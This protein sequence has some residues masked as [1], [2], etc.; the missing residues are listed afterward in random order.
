MKALG[1]ALEVVATDGDLLKIDL[2]D[3]LN[4]PVLVNSAEVARD[5]KTRYSVPDP[6]SE[7]ERRFDFG[8]D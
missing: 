7:T 2:E 5:A 8:S 1:A 6:L 3:L 4:A